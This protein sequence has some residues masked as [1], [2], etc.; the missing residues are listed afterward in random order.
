MD[1]S[2]L[3][4]ASRYIKDVFYCCSSK[5]ACLFL[6]HNGYFIADPVFCFA[7]AT[8][9]LGAKLDTIFIMVRL[10]I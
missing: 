5:M 7:L 6:F 9:R 4:A 1:Y 2:L 3:P 8:R 10:V